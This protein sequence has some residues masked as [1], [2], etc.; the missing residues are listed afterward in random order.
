MQGSLVSAMERLTLWGA[1][2]GMFALLGVVSV[3]TADVCLRRT[4]GITVEGNVDVTQLLVMAAASLAIPFTFMTNR[5]VV[6]TVLSDR[7]GAR[8]QLLLKGIAALLSAAFM[9]IIFV[10]GWQQAALQVRMGDVSQTIGIPMIYYWVPLL[11]GT[12]MSAVVTILLALGFVRA[13]FD[14][15][16]HVSS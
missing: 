6:V 1:M 12:G 5:H 4:L 9:A 10:Y 8:K 13:A 15:A 7:L 14:G 2:A 11:T 3:T 16:S